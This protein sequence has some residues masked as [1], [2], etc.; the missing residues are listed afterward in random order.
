MNSIKVNVRERIALVTID[1]GKTNAI[2]TE[3]VL[4]LKDLIQNIEKDDNISAVILTGKGDYFSAGLDLVELF[5]YTEDQIKFFWEQYFSL[6]YILTA[7]KKPLVAAINGQA[8]GIGTVISLCADY[9]VVAD[10]DFKL[11]L[12][13][14]S[15][16][17]IVP[18]SIY[19]LYSVWIGRNKASK[20]ILD[21]KLLN[22]AEAL[23]LGLADEVVRQDLVVNAAVK[24]VQRYLQYNKAVWQ[25]SKLNLRRN[26]TFAV[27][28]HQPDLIKKI[29]EEWWAPYNRSILHTIIQNFKKS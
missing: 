17:I 20:F 1:E 19:Q 16:G 28:P 27:Q 24:Q 10:G 26:I 25:E 21:A 6:I 13:E 15:L 3:I 29:L 9:R 18:D 4:E 23:Q 12:N 7:F 2:G 8:P 22:P 14:I 5:D 11:G